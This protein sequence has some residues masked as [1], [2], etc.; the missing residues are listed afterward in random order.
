MRIDRNEAIVLRQGGSTYKDIQARLGVPLS[1]LSSWFKNEKWSNEI[2]L[3]AVRRSRNSA[4][5]RLVVMNTIRGGRLRKIYEEAGQDAFV[6]FTELKFHPLFMAGVL[7]YSAHGD[8]TARSRIALSSSDPSTVSIFK[9]FIEKVC[10]VKNIKVQLLGLNESV[11]A[12]YKAFWSS[13]LGLT[14][15]IFL[16]SALT[17]KKKSSIRPYYGV[18]NIIVN[19]AYLKSKILRWIEL[20]K[21]EL[22][23]DKYLNGLESL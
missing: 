3:E 7:L 6:D 4:A 2:A 12:E 22:S 1:T 16:K 14:N 11:E 19:S 18:C 13:K 20:M 23:T 10:G 15:D 5:I 21:G 9:S 8:K 17:A